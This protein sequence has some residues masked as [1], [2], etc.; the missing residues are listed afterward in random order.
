VFVH[1]WQH[2]GVETHFILRYHSKSYFFTKN[3][4]QNP[5]I[6]PTGHA[7]HLY[8]KAVRAYHLMC[9]PRVPF[10][11]FVFSSVCHRASVRAPG[12]CSG[13]ARLPTLLPRPFASVETDGTI[14][15]NLYFMLVVYKHHPR[16]L[17]PNALV[18]S[19]LM[20]HLRGQLV[21]QPCGH[22]CYHPVQPAAVMGAPRK[23]WVFDYTKDS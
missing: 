2:G 23:L 15:P 10:C 19:N 11:R 12:Q 7:P 9:F 1:L 21:G 22:L 6:L 20:R 13:T 14:Q 16:T 4:F 5:Y 8:E 17:L 3:Q 18:A